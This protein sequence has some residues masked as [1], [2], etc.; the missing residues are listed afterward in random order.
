MGRLGGL[1]EPSWKHLGS[2]WKPL[3]AS[4]KPLGELLEASRVPLDLPGEPLGP[5]R[6][7]FESSWGPLGRLLKGLEDRLAM[8]SKTFIF[9]MEFID[10]SGLGRCSG[11][12]GEALGS[13][14]SAP[15]ALLGAVWAHLELLKPSWSALGRSWSRATSIGID[16]GPSWPALGA[17]NTHP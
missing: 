4:W 6:V 13:P 1:L 14:W 16:L 7:R 15:G 2:S 17:E 10:F 11:A 3:G 8:S 9:S 5:S 12:P